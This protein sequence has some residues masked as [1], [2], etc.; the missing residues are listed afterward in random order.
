MAA[1]TLGELW[2]PVEEEEEESYLLYVGAY[3]LPI[4]MLYKICFSYV[5]MYKITND[6]YILAYNNRHIAFIISQTNKNLNVTEWLYKQ[7]LIIFLLI[8]S[9]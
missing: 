4:Y 3:C 7:R 9:Q 6:K 5:F 8:N 1:K 2:R